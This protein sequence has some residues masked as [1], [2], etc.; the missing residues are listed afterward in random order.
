MRLPL[1]Q[2][3]QVKN[4]G[5]FFTDESPICGIMIKQRR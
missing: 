3:Q 4:L 5:I 2:V 1:R